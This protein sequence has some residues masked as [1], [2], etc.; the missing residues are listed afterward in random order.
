MTRRGCYLRLRDTR[1]DDDQHESDRCSHFTLPQ[2]SDPQTYQVLA[3]GCFRRLAA[4]GCLHEL[5][6]SPHDH[7]SAI[8]GNYLYGVTNG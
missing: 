2:L 5:T 7:N 1:C 4:I 8:D 6:A 3:N